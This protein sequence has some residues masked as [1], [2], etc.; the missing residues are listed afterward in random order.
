M[1]PSHWLVFFCDGGTDN[2]LHCTTSSP[3]RM[4]GFQID[5]LDSS[6]VY[7][8]IRRPSVVQFMHAHLPGGERG[9]SAVCRHRHGKVVGVIGCFVCFNV[10][11]MEGE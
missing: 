1:G 9:G 8:Y 5:N 2:G 4:P 11:E 3:R 6:A 10:E 7:I